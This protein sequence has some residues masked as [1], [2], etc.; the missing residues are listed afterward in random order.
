MFFLN[1]QSL[2]WHV[3]HYIPKNN[4]PDI[5]PLSF[6]T[7][8]PNRRWNPQRKTWRGWMSPL[9]SWF[10]FGGLKPKPWKT[11]FQFDFTCD[12]VMHF[13]GFLMREQQQFSVGS[14]F[15]SP[16][17][18]GCF[19][20]SWARFTVSVSVS[21]YG[22]YSMAV[23]MGITF[24]WESSLQSQ[25]SSDTDTN[26]T[27]GWLR[28]NSHGEPFLDIL[29]T[30]AHPSNSI[31]LDW[32]NVQPVGSYPKFQAFYVPFFVVSIPALK[33]VSSASPHHDQLYRSFQERNTRGNPWCFSQYVP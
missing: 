28:S 20:T 18:V 11:P 31:I 21:E 2:F 12:Y 27:L 30:L 1:E 25:K 23:S 7:A 8:R 14:V 22:L 9:F 32:Q 10:Q 13:V 26:R 4:S 6:P 17:A 19:S 16:G 29:D 15:K 33:G 5:P 24:E 3:I